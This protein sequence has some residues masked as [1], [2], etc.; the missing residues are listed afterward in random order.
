MPIITPAYPSMCATHNITHSTKEVIAREISRANNIATDIAMAK[1]P[2]KELFV[3]HNFFCEGYKYYLS[4]ISGSRTKDA[5]QIWE[6]LVQS[7][8]RRLVSGI[9]MSETGVKL[10][11]PFTKGFDRVHKCKSEDEVDKIFQGDL[12]FQVGE[13]ELTTNENGGIGDE[14][15]SKIEASGVNNDENQPL[16]IYTTT[17]Y[18]GLELG[19]QE[20]P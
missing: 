18:V 7:K 15:F 20:G 16:T 12:S 10:A 4:I 11:H 13:T 14:G 8:V 19:V 2:W 17:F 6:G 9:E 3:K 5:Q 1:K